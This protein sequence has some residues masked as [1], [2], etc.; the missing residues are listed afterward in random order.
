MKR[1][2]DPVV[3]P[4]L[5]RAL[6]ER[7]HMTGELF[8][9]FCSGYADSYRKAKRLAYD[10]EVSSE[11]GKD[12]GDAYIRAQ[13]FYNM[14]NYL[15]R[16]GL[17][18]KKKSRER[19][20]QWAITARGKRNLK[21]RQ[22]EAWKK[23]KEE[24]DKTFRVVIFDVP[25]RDKAQREWLRETLRS[26]GFLLLQDSVWVGARK[27]PERFLFE[28]KERDLIPCVHIFEVEKEGSIFVAD[29]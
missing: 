5:L 8:D 28:L 22:R 1:G 11:G 29:S 17:I 27:I 26:L 4:A 16:Q 21:D 20:A 24:K 23:Y 9:V 2:K 7:V 6:Q 18:E 19:Q 3:V 10:G 14:L 13:R 25:E 15:K 12:W